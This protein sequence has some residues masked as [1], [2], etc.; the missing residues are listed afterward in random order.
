[1]VGGGEGVGAVVVGGGGGEA[2]AERA[3]RRSGSGMWS[4]LAKT[5]PGAVRA[6]SAVYRAARESRSIQCSAVEDTAAWI[7]PGSTVIHSGSARSAWIQVA[8]SP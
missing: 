5:P 2:G 1:M 8:V 6:A 4:A 3:V 7:V